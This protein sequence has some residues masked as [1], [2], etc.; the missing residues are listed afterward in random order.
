MRANEFCYWLQGYFE[1]GGANHVIDNMDVATAHIIK[2]HLRIV[3]KVEPRHRNMFV[4][5]LV[6]Q[7]ASVDTSDKALRD[8]CAIAVDKDGV[9]QI[10]NYLATQ[11]KH[12]ID[13]SYSGDAKDLQAIH[14][15]KHNPPTLAVPASPQRPPS[16]GPFRC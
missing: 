10:R 11:F 4:D 2:A 14:D 5:W 9:D 15:G 6:M 1:L 7:L 12:D 3:A 8:S 16:E 13:L